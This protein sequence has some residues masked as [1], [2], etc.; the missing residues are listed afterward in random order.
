[1][2]TLLQTL[3]SSV[4]V[5]GSVSSRETEDLVEYATKVIDAFCTQ[6]EVQISDREYAKREKEKDLSL[7]VVGE[8][9]G[10]VEDRA[11]LK[12]QGFVSFRSN[13]NEEK[14]QNSFHDKIDNSNNPF[15]P[16]YESLENVDGVDVKHY[17]QE[18]EQ[19]LS[20]G[21]PRPH[22]LAK[23]L[24]ALP[25]TYSAEQIK[26]ATCIKIPQNIEDVELRYVDTLEE[27]KSLAT[28]LGG[29]KEI[30]VDLEAHNYRSFQGFCCL[31][32]ISTRDIDIIVDVLKLRRYIGKILG[33]IFA[34]PSIVKVFHGSRSDLGWLQRDFGIYVCNLFDT[35]IAS[36]ALQYEN[37]GLAFLLKK[38]CNFD[39]DKKWQLADWRVR[40]LQTKAIH[41]ARA[42]THFLLYCY[43]VLRRELSS[44]HKLDPRKFSEPLVP[45]GGTLGICAVL[46]E[47]RK[48]CLSLYEKELFTPYSFYDLYK[49]MEGK[50]GS[51]TERQLSVFAALYE[52]RDSLC[53]QLDESTGYIMPRGELFH[54]AVK[55]PKSKRALQDSLKSK[56][57]FVMNRSEEVLYLIDK[58]LKDTSVVQRAMAETQDDNNSLKHTMLTVSKTKG[59]APT[60][61]QKKPGDIQP[62]LGGAFSMFESLG[63]DIQASGIQMKTS[64][65]LGTMVKRPTRLPVTM[66]Y[67][68]KPTPN[69]A[70]DEGILKNDTPIDTVPGEEPEQQPPAVDESPID[71]QSDEKEEND[72]AKDK[73]L[74]QDMPLGTLDDD[75]FLPL[76]VSH[77][78]A[79]KRK[80]VGKPPKNAPL[81]QNQQK[82]TKPAAT[83]DS[84]AKNTDA[85]VASFDPDKAIS[86]YAYSKKHKKFDRKDKRAR[87]RSSKDDNTFIIPEGMFN[88]HAGLLEG[89]SSSKRSATQ[90]RSGNRSS[91][92]K[93]R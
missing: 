28:L 9:T 16:K 6:L 55:S 2:T 90:V 70:D 49:R 75:A 25:H 32:Q 13:S 27:L 89:K 63:I 58:A 59:V 64:S 42:D 52:W 1:V 3:G 93:K 78:N 20:T 48:L 37:H 71:N 10:V 23:V 8:A 76:P 44:L 14:P 87:P 92:Y 19:A 74:S 65:T 73:P 29:E 41:Y 67:I 26:E 84:P 46:E 15:V 24:E 88:P 91:S 31:M 82:K 36:Q 72:M 38:H 22:P 57:R 79:K 80:S 68:D 61:G 56:N 7:N 34:N 18:Y 81:R 86:K 12:A 66:K 17:R 43:D 21:V 30:A 69:A 62:P 39:A 53:R 35:G 4:N 47:S 40:P 51:L 85:A 50:S 11:M 45:S 33:P 83:A 77:L 5:S 60:P 54:L